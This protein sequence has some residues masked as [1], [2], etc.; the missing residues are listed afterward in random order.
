MLREIFSA[1]VNYAIENNEY[2]PLCRVLSTQVCRQRIIECR[3]C[4]CVC[5]CV[6]L[7][8][9]TLHTVCTRHDES[10]AKVLHLNASFY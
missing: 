3:F 4:V 1:L 6:S 7:C 5:V 10:G 8:V 2:V 9:M